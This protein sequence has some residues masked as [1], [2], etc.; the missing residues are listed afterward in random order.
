M[1]IPRPHPTLMA[2]GDRWPRAVAPFPSPPIGVILGG[3]L[4]DLPLPRLYTDAYRDPT[5]RETR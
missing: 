4:G 2:I 1:P 5:E 3:Q